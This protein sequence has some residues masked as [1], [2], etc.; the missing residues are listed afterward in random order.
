MERFDPRIDTYIEKSADFAKPIL[1]HIRDLVHR[2]SP[3]VEETMKW[4]FPHFE[5]KGTICSMASFKAHCAFGFWNSDPHHILK[6]GS[7][8]AMGQ[9]GRITSV[10]DL[11]PD[12]ILASY[13]HEAI[14]L[15]EQGIKVSRNSDRPSDPVP[16]PGYFEEILKSH[17]EAK[18]NF[19]KFSNSH[20]KEYIGWF[21]EAKTE[22]TRNKRINQ[23][24]EW[25]VEG[26]SR[27]WKFERK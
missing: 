2:A 18:T 7:S 23:A 1:C 24:I 25:L 21:E 19:D 27:N 3:E 10:D 4:G 5:Y 6:K 26:K 11:P 16:T 13:I 22:E 17:P 15:N 14:I 8:E 12:D 20:R 9:F